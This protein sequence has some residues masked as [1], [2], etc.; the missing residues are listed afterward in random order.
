MLKYVERY[1][2]HSYTRFHSNNRVMWQYMV[3]LLQ[4]A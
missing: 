2:A 3:F 4:L 1:H